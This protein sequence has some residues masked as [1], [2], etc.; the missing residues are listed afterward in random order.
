MVCD[1]TVP[2][3]KLPEVLSKVLETG[4]KYGLLIGNVF[5]AGDGNLHPL[6]L[7]DE[8]DEKEMARV[9]KATSE[10]LKICADAG[11]TISGEHGIG[12]EK[13]KEMSFVFSEN[14]LDVMRQVKKAFD[15]E[16]ILN[17]GKVVPEA[18]S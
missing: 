11:G 9:L 15:P 8:R 17:P 1:G 18:I 6:I 2:R 12:I 13:L 5:H 16:G 7:F 3:T 4:E 14:D 10:I